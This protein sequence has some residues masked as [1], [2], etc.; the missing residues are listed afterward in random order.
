[1]CDGDWKNLNVGELE[2]CNFERTRQVEGKL[3]KAYQNRLRELAKA[4]HV[5]GVSNAKVTKILVASQK[6]WEQ[7]RK[8]QCNFL[9]E[10]MGEASLGP[11]WH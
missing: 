4:T 6:A 10:Q 11:S 7:Y 1:M 5:T 3:R 2:Q 8:L 9:L